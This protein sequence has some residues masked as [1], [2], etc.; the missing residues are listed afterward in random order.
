[1]SDAIDSASLVAEGVVESTGRRLA[2]VFVDDLD[3]LPRRTHAGN[4]R[5]AGRC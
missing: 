2:F 3:G 1:M 4:V 5:G